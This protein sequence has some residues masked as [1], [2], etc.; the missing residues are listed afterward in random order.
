MHPVAILLEGPGGG[1]WLVRPNGSVVLGRAD[2]ATALIAGY[3]LEFLEWGT[4]RV[5][6]RD[7]DVK[8]SGDVGYA[9][10]FIDALHVV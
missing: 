8:V 6:W 2:S 3:A 1:S 9:T 4:R 10:R 5:D 7:R